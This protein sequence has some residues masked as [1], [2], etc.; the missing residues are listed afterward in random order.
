M[1][2]IS[3]GVGLIISSITSKYRDLNLALPFLLQL[4]MFASPVVY[5]FSL[6]PE[7]YKILSALNPMTSVIEL[8]RGMFFGIT[9]IN[10]FYVFISLSVAITLFIIGLILFF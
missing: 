2:L 7:G 4:G 1:A 8:F 10:M 6:I 5:P 3:I 9:D